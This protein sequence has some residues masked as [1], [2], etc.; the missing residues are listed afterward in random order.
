MTEFRIRRAV[1]SDASDI[2]SIYNQG[3]DERMAT[4]NIEYVTPEER[5]DR[6]EK[7]GDKHPVLVATALDQAG[8]DVL[9]AGW[10]S[11]SPYSPRSCYS[12]I[13]EVSIYIAKEYRGKGIGKAL[14]RSLV[15]AAVQQGYWKLMGRAFVSNTAIRAL[16][17]GLGFE[18]IGIHEKHG[19]L[20][21]RWIDVVEMERLIPENID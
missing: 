7:G 14:L 9:V 20:A 13:G 2:A 8:G 15:D 21:G 10:A 18:E 1:T 6:I 16:C 3:I 12:G 11:I 4:F 19:K 17:K 5:S